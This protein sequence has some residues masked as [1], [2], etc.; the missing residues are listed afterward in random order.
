MLSEIQSG[1]VLGGRLFEDF[2]TLGFNKIGID[3]YTLSTRVKLSETNL[4]FDCDGIVKGQNKNHIIEIKK[5]I[6]DSTICKIYCQ[7]QAW[8]NHFLK[9]NYTDWTFTVIVEEMNRI[10][11]SYLNKLKDLPNFRYIDFK[12]LKKVNWK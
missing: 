6:S 10:N 9:E 7:Y 11:L 1:R 4:T 5:S 2:V 3:V 12:N 8:F